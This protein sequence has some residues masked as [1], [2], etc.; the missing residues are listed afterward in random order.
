M[1]RGA[2]AHRDELTQ[3]RTWETHERGDRKPTW[4]QCGYT[5]WVRQL[6]VTKTIHFWQKHSPNCDFMGV[7]PY[8]I[9]N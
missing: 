5:G 7:P 1:R 9:P 6:W 3:R 8:P 2:V 4:A